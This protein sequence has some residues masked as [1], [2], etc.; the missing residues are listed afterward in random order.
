MTQEKKNL[1]L[2][3]GKYPQVYVLSKIKL[4]RKRQVS[5]Y[6]NYDQRQQDFYNHEK[7]VAQMP[8]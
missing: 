2:C 4:K 6:I 1:L 3:L 7:D 5:F 8:V